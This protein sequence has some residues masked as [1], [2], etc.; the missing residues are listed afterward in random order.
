M[1]NNGK[2]KLCFHSCRRGCTEWSLFLKTALKKKIIFIL[3]SVPVQ[4]AFPI[5]QLWVHKICSNEISFYF[6]SLKRWECCVCFKSRVKMANTKKRTKE[7]QPSDV[8]GLLMVKGERAGKATWLVGKSQHCTA[9]NCH[10]MSPRNGTI[11]SF[12]TKG[13]RVLFTWTDR[14]QHRKTRWWQWTGPVVSVSL[15]TI[16]CVLKLINGCN[17]IT[18]VFLEPEIVLGW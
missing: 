5:K 4:I 16:Y 3:F 9:S 11:I 2:C 18:T 13:S 1:I 10:N 12:C 14:W 17:G 6:L 15:W 8:K 7:K